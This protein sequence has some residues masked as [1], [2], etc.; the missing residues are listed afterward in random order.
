MLLKLLKITIV[1]ATIY[2]AV[3]EQTDSTPFITASNKVINKANPQGHRWVAVSRDLEALGFTF[4]TYICVEG[5]GNMDGLWRVEDRMNKRF[6]QRIDF[7]V[8]EEMRGGKWEN[9]KIW[10]ESTQ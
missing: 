8:N 9:V 6:T 1:T 2:H 5:A 10:I 7:L 4:G 3:P